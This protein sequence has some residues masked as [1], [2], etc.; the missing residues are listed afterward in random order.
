MTAARRLVDIS[1]VAQLLRARVD[2]LVRELLPDGRRNGAEWTA[3]NPTRADGNVGSFNV[4]L[5]G[6]K[7]GVWRDFATG[8]GGDPLDLVAYLLF[9]GDK[10]RAFAWSRRWLG[11]DSGDPAALERVRRSIPSM[12]EREQQAQAEQDD[13]RNAAF[14]IWLAA[15]PKLRDTPV[16]LYLRGRGIP[17]AELSR[18]PRSIR[19]HPGLWHKDSGRKWPAM[20]TAI[21]GADGKF[22]ACHRTW[23]EVRP[24][25]SVRKAPI[26]RNKKVLG[27]YKGC[28]IHL[29]RGASGKP[30]REAPEGEIADITEGIEDGLSVVVAA[31]ECRVLVAI[32]IDNMA[33]VPLPPAITAVRLWRQNDKAPEAIA[34]FQKAARAHVAAGRDVLAPPIPLDLKDVND[35][36][37]TG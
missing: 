10:A 15:E 12:A 30:L 20:V 26:D 5:T 27:S 29:W 23:L 19:F 9:G 33:N 24:D 3:R 32:S 34:S 21:S 8:D 2:S 17:L 13:A 18:A 16:D 1:E 37:R 7:A 14:R 4:H 28:S 6:G 36:L 25:G 22:A 31:P 11:L 35:L